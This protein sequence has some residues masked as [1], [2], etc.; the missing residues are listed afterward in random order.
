ML[1]WVR[2]ALVLACGILGG[3]A[4]ATEVTT[5]RPADV[6][7]TSGE[8]VTIPGGTF[9]QG[10]DLSEINDL[11]TA[12]RAEHFGVS[13]VLCEKD[14]YFYK[15]LGRTREVYLSSYAIDRYEVSVRQ[16]RR[17][18]TGGG[19]DRLPLVSGDTRG[20]LD[21]LP[22]ANVT[23][24][25][26]GDYCRWAG[27]RL[28]TEAEWEKAARGID[29]RRWPWGMADGD[30]RANR[31]QAAAPVVWTFNIGLR[32]WVPDYVPDGR[33][34]AS[35]PTPPGTYAW[36]ASP[37]GAQ[38]MSGNV[39]EW[40]ED[41]LGEVG[42]AGLSPINPLNTVAG[43]FGWRVVRGGGYDEP[44]YLTR[45]YVRSAADPENRSPSRG[46][47]CVRDML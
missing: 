8:M 17:C 21:E 1:S 44:H 36:G 38:D 2:S 33:D 3:A 31:G 22:M 27:G 9:V 16:Y 26:A 12:C 10:V 18:V 5:G 13:T 45:T 30:A 24:R 15:L 41:Y 11:R 28:P 20:L 4:G 46:F 35:G 47:R 43:R 6:R 23:W 14:D 39:S 42:Y 34:G 19:C 37:Y 7:G 25:E 29:G 40:V 32:E